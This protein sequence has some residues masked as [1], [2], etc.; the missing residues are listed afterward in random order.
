MGVKANMGVTGDVAGDPSEPR[1][2]QIC[3]FTEPVTKQ[4]VIPSPKFFLD[5]VHRQWNQPGAIPV[6]SGMDRRMYTGEQE[7]ED[8]LRVP[9]V[10]APLANLALA[11]LIASD[12]AEG[13]KAKDR[14]AE[15]SAHKTHQAAAWAIRSTIAA[16]FFTRTSLI[17]LHQL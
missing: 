17:W 15:L 5:V 4:E 2:P 1:D 8:L 9:S 3:L 12:T 10:Y 16:S 7:L 11:A 6:P 13:L 14:K